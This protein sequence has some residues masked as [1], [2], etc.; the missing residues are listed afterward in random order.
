MWPAYES[1]PFSTV[2]GSNDQSCSTVE[3]SRRDVNSG[4]DGS[5]VESGEIP[6]LALECGQFVGF[7]WW[8]SSSVLSNDKPNEHYVGTAIQNNTNHL[9]DSGSQ[10]NCRSCPVSSDLD[11]RYSFLTGHSS[12]ED[13]VPTNFKRTNSRRR[14]SSHSG[15]LDLI[16]RSLPDLS[17]NLSSV[18]ITNASTSFTNVNDN[19][20]NVIE[21]NQRIEGMP[22][23]SCQDIE[24]SSEPTSSCVSCEWIQS[25]TKQEKLILFS[26]FLV[27]FTS[28]MCLSIMAPFF[29]QEV[30]FKFLLMKLA[31]FQPGI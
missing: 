3:I 19:I 11:R 15:H 30:G 16:T 29:P 13:G 31:Q 14:S 22:S 23:A 12:L 25:T 7:H 2:D 28:Q 17:H 20:R 9:I 5:V 4:R 10:S 21:I 6:S 26:L 27:D 24:T 8:N 1:N 18:D